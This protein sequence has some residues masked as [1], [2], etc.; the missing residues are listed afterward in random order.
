VRDPASRKPVSNAPGRCKQIVS[1]KSL[2]WKLLPV[3]P[4]SAGFCGQPVPSDSSNSNRI[5]ILP[6]FDVKKEVG[7]AFCSV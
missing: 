4:Y 5:N 3:S 2:F 1:A 7:M 6:F